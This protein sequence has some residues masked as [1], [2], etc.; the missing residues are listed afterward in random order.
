MAVRIY[1]TCKHTTQGL[2]WTNFGTILNV[3][4]VSEGWFH[5]W[6]SGGAKVRPIPWINVFQILFLWNVRSK[7]RV[8]EIPKLWAISTPT[9]ENFPHFYFRSQGIPY[10]TPRLRPRQWVR[11]LKLVK[12]SWC[13][14][15][16]WSALWC[17][18]YR[19]TGRQEEHTARENKYERYYGPGRWR[20]LVKI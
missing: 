18:W 20:H 17:C 10:N 14:S 19:I 16:H 3:A 9:L 11:A 4:I 5:F 7:N 13:N 12:L 15:L 8:F 1:S 6:G 2:L